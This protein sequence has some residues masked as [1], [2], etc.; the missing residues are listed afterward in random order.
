MKTIKMLT[1]ALLCGLSLTA[2]SDDD[3]KGGGL[4]NNVADVYVI[5]NGNMN[6]QVPG[7]ITSYN[8]MAKTSVLGAFSTANGRYI[9]SS[10]ESATIGRNRIYLVSTNENTVEVA[11]ART[12]KSIKTINMTKLFGNYGVQPRYAQYYDGDVYVTTYA[13]Y[14]CA[15]DADDFEKEEVFQVGSYPEEISID[16]YGIA[17][18]ANSDYGQGKNASISRIDLKT[19]TVTTITSELIKNPYQIIASPEKLWVLDRGSYDA[20]W[21]Q[22][23]A[24]LYEYDIKAQSW[25]K[26]ADATLMSKINGEGLVICNA[27][28]HTPPVKP[29]Y[30]YVNIFTGSITP[31]NDIKVDNPCFVGLDPLGTSIY[32]GSNT[33]NP[34]TGYANYND[35]GYVKVYSINGIERDKFTCGVGPMCIIFVNK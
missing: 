15:F 16:S 32:V 14:V 4:S 29:T 3:D 18:V 25:K 5:C 20:S 11:D 8:P 7:S 13:G 12:L 19:E 17:W 22:V 1:L 2:C 6:T 24:G 34:D 10:V 28:F 26:L 33:V 23:G 27:P 35:N 21:N 9:G 31:L 30:S